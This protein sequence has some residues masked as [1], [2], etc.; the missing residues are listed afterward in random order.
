MTPLTDEEKFE[1][2]INLVGALFRLTSQDI[3]QGDQSAVQFIESE[4]YVEICDGLQV[5][6]KKFKYYILTKR[7]KS[8]VSYE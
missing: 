5:D 7:V 3:K 1:G 6:A 2:I 4:W 8:R